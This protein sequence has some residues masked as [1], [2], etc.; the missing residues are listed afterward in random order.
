MPRQHL[1]E[2]AP[3]TCHKLLLPG[4]GGSDVSLLLE[5][6][7]KRSLGLPGEQ[8]TSDPGCTQPPSA[9]SV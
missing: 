3:K 9:G 2:A 8:L 1:I 4:Y 5:Q 7:H 6:A